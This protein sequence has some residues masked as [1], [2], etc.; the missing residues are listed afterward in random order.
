M[1]SRI[2]STSW[3]FIRVFL[4]AMLTMLVLSAALGAGV[5]AQENNKKIYVYTDENGNTVFT[6]KAQPNAKQVDV[7][8]NIMTMPA[9]DDQVFLSEILVRRVY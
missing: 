9:T 8:T 3:Q 7:K 5:N 1:N 4:T 2:S 6:D